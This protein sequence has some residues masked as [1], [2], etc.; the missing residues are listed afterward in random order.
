[1]APVKTGSASELDWERFLCS[2]QELEEL[3]KN[4]D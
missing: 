3:N 1:M 4:I 2:H